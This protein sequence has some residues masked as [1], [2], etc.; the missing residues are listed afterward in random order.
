MSSFFFWF[1]KN[2]TT[3]KWKEWWVVTSGI[4]S[5]YRWGYL[6]SET[7]NNLPKAPQLGIGR[8]AQN[9]SFLL[10]CFVLVQCSF[11]LVSLAPCRR[12]LPSLLGSLSLYKQSRQV[13]EL[14]R[15]WVIC[16]Y[17]FPLLGWRPQQGSTW[18]LCVFSLPVA[19]RLCRC[20]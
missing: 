13:G 14:K 11:P 1:L 5:F 8:V 19:Q 9:T 18:W 15:R 12:Y 2:N 16:P 3:F 4:S 10:P 7:S 17:M 20:S 6:S